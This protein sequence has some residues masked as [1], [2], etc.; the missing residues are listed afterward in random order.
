M[1]R[2]EEESIMKKCVTI[3]SNISIQEEIIE[4]LTSV[5]AEYFTQF[6]RILG[7]GEATGARFDNHVWPGANTG[8]TVITD[9]K[10][11]EKLMDK[12]Q[13]MR[14]SLIGKQSGIYAFQTSVERALS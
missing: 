11:A 3:Y 4:L 14:N 13:E 12:L 5:G 1:R 9:E 7:K 10:T 6:P 8:F 2:K